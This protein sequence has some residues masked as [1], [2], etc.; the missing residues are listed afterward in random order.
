M[1]HNV[2]YSTFITSPSA[3]CWTR[4][5]NAALSFKCADDTCAKNTNARS[6]L[7]AQFGSGTERRGVLG[8][9]ASQE[10]PSSVGGSSCTSPGCPPGRAQDQK[11]LWMLGCD[12]PS[13][14][15]G[16]GNIPQLFAVHWFQS[17][18]HWCNSLPLLD[19]FTIFASVGKLCYIWLF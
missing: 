11:W 10:R 2:D 18:P 6:T 13:L 5:G 17:P 7:T 8:P 3:P 12:L 19:C 15:L 1:R 14:Q 4:A 16:G 9:W